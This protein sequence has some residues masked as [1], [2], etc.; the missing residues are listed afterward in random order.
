MTT[1]TRTVRW[2]PAEVTVG[3]DRGAVD[4]ARIHTAIRSYEVIP[5]EGDDPDCWMGDASYHVPIPYDGPEWEEWV[6]LCE[7]AADDG[8]LGRTGETV[9]SA[10]LARVLDLDGSARD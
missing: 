7:G 10:A 9:I 1:H 6:A 4:G 8:A 2:E 3:D 5:R